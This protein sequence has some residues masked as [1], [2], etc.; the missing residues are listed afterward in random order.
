MMRLADRKL[1]QRFWLVGLLVGWL[2]LLLTSPAWANDRSAEIIGSRFLLV[3]NWMN[4]YSLSG[5]GQIV[6]IA[7]SGLDKG[8]MT[9]IHPDL[10]ST[11]GVMPKVFYLKSYTDRAIADD[12]SGHGTF[13]AATIAGNGQASFGKYQ[14]IAPGASLY[15]QALLDKNGVLQ[16]PQDINALFAPAYSAGV[17]IHVNGWGSGSNVYDEKAA[18]IDT[19]VYQHP[20]FLPVFA[21]GNAG[22]GSGTLTAQA[23]SK[24]GLII[25]ASQ[26]P[27][28][29][30]DPESNYAD[31]IWAL[32]S[33]GPAGDGRGKPDLLVPGSALIS[34]RSSLATGNFPANA[35][36]TRMGGTSMAA[37]VA[38]GALALLR[39]QLQV[40]FGV[41][42]PSSALLKAL[43]INGA[44]DGG[45]NRSQ[46]GYGILDSAA[47]ALA[48]QDNTFQFVD[49]PR[50]LAEGEVKEYKLTVT[51]STMPLN[52]TLAWVDPA[53]IAGSTALINNLDIIVQSPDGKLHYGNDFAA[54]GSTDNRNNVEKVSIPS[55]K[56]GDYIIKIRAVK[57]GSREGQ[58]YALVFGQSLQ[59][60]IVSAVRG[61]IL[62]LQDGSQI[63][64]GHT[65]LRNVVDGII[66]NSAQKVLIGSYLYRGPTKVYVTGKTWHTGGI[67]GLSTPTGELLLEMNS[68]ARD[69]GYFL[70]PQ[71]ANHTGTVSVNDRIVTGIEG[72][73]SGSEL[74]AH[75]NPVHQTLWRM[76]ASNQEI[77]GFIGSVIIDRREI[78]LLNQDRIYPVAAWAALSY[79]DK[80]VDCSLQDSPYGTAETNN[81]EQIMPGT[82]VVMQISPHSGAVQSLLLER[83]L[84][85]GKLTA[86]NKEGDRITL[87]TGK[88]YHLIDGTQIYR[89]GQ[90]AEARELIAG[91]HLRAQLLPGTNTIIQVQA[92]SQVSYGRVV[93]SSNNLNS[94]Y[95]MDYNNRGRFYNLDEFSQVFSWAMPLET[96]AVDSG[97]WARITADSSGQI[98]RRIDLATDALSPKTLKGFDPTRKTLTMSDGSTC[99]YQPF[100]RI[101]N[102]GYGLE[103]EDL[104]PGQNVIVTTL[105]S[106]APGASVVAE[107]EAEPLALT[108]EPRLRISARALNGVLIIQGLTDADRVYLYRQDGSRE[109]IVVTDGRFSAAF[110]SLANEKKIQAV[111]LQTASGRL[112]SIELDIGA[113]LSEAASGTFSDISGHWAQS[114][115]IDLTSRG[116]LH[117][118]GDGTFRPDQ[119]LN[120]TELVAIVARWQNLSALAQPDADIFQDYWQIPWWGRSAVSS[121]WEAGL[122]TG[123]PD[124]YFWPDR[125]VTR[126]ELEIIIARI[127]DADN[128]NLFPG[129]SKQPNLPVT[130]A[131]LA[132]ILAKQQ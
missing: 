126:A 74:R 28:P 63:N 45:D 78:T 98:A 92:Y 39:E 91:D 58:N 75:V 18:A 14:G 51:D 71:A 54:K 88:S 99:Q 113:Y 118:Y 30:F 56:T 2:V 21:A 41:N 103:A 69:G 52:A 37:A 109:R 32:S 19:F 27:R 53:G 26:L 23:N 61:D 127:R 35:Y 68:S 85:I 24:N 72:I 7:D 114:Y 34:A 62:L 33:S 132:A 65:T 100:T 49:E 59:T 107:V 67:Q 70:D 11:T 120:R 40:D 115:I 25:G 81:W 94:L 31:Q 12:P 93:Y 17:R 77:S 48:L 44:R 128:I 13:M 42:S 46:K 73:P 129:E 22:P 117:G 83:Q 131:Q 57:L 1:R 96:S 43:L 76:Q 124:R 50:R 122:I 82:K 3:K 10:S 29:A 38:G 79:R 123:S 55:P 64:L 106:S 104:T 6:G 66:A 15:F 47:T 101:S 84:A 8:S 105:L 9:D 95:I 80:L 20:D 112:K 111:A 102:G 119:V 36:Y 89:D 87:D 90:L 60:G 108:E 110:K 130:R 16:V 116:I 86:V 4:T 5:R 97:R 125:T 121:A